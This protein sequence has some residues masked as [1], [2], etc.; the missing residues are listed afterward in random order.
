MYY[1]LAYFA[2]ANVALC[3]ILHF[4]VSLYYNYLIIITILTYNNN[5]E[6][7]LYLM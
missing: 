1:Q 7:I 3:S 4:I 5:D 6:H 2:Y